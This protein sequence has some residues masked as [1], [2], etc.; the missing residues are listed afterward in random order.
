MIESGRGRDPRFLT[1]RSRIPSGRISTGDSEKPI[2]LQLTSHD[3]GATSGNI[4]AFDLRHPPPVCNHVL[5]FIVAYYLH[6][7][8]CIYWDFGRGRSTRAWDSRAGHRDARGTQNLAG[9]NGA[10]ASRQEF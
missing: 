5:S 3:V 7:R 2:S 10:I 6:R 9:T 1:G 8:V 4:S